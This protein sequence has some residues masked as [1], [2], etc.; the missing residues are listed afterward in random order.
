MNGPDSCELNSVVVKWNGCEVNYG[1]QYQAAMMDDEGVF[2][3]QYRGGEVEE[4]IGFLM[5]NVVGQCKVGSLVHGC[6]V[7]LNRI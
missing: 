3:L 6:H 4:T 7:G 2:G 1:F 5:E